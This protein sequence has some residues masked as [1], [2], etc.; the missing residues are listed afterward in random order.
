[1][2]ICLNMIVRDEAHVI[3]KTL[4]AVCHA[5]PINYWVISDTGSF[6]GTQD[7]VRTTFRA[8]GI[9]GELREDPWADF[10]TNRNIALR[11]CR[12]KSEYILFF[13]AD[14]WIEG[15]PELPALQADVYS[16]QM[17]NENR[18]RQY[19]R[20]LLV[21]NNEKLRWR[22]VVHE[23]LEVPEANREII[24]GSY[25]II[26]G[27]SGSRSKDPEKYKKDAELLEK[28][29]RSNQEQDLLPR[30]A[31]YC[32]NSWRD[33]GDTERALRWYIARSK[34][35][36]WK[37]E[38]YMAFLEAGLHL[39]KTGRA[40]L[41]LDFFLRGH[42][43][44]PDRAECLYH[45]SRSLRHRGQFQAALIFA[46]EAERIPKPSGHRL[47]LNKAIYEYW[48][49]YE[50]LFLTAKTGGDPSYS[51]EYSSFMASAAPESSKASIQKLLFG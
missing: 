37:E 25:A 18:T 48:I 4:R 35:N 29:I 10:A 20:P 16:L 9:P 26:S 40:D 23:F 47:F 8:L 42:N 15:V 7:L 24:T 51:A 36:G 14:D 33:H 13:D 5:F 27:R 1:M 45:A 46:K 11:S 17:E 41:A 22:G 19:T 21:K 39:E 43:L 50:V 6:D 30:Y 3:A 28:A 49:A 32:A 31:Y 38:S 34:L 12:G 2:S 44:V